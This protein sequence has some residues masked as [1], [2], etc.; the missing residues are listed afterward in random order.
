M[1]IGVSF[2]TRLCFCHPSSFT[3][4][5]AHRFC[6]YS[7]NANDQCVCQRPLSSSSCLPR[8]SS[9]TVCASF[10]AAPGGGLPMLAPQRTL[11]LTT[12]RRGYSHSAPPLSAMR[13][14]CVSACVYSK[15]RAVFVRVCSHG[16]LPI[17]FRA[18][19]SSPHTR[20]KGLGG[21]TPSPSL[22]SDSISVN[23]SILIIPSCN[24]HTYTNT[25]WPVLRTC[26]EAWNRALWMRAA[27]LI[28][29]CLL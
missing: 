29:I 25:P 16:L 14:R 20:L 2:R 1:S 17:L 21:V 26:G 7:I 3:V 23:G 6:I 27:V 11:P 13:A 12:V 5:Y 10:V 28:L 22:L 18:L 9:S 24:V 15:S 4:M 8:I 19:S